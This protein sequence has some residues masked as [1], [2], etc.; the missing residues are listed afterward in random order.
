MKLQIIAPTMSL[1][2]AT[3]ASAFATNS[4]RQLVNTIRPYC[5]IENGFDYQGNDVKNVP[6]TPVDQCCNLCNNVDGCKAWSWTTYNNGTCWLKSARDNIVVNPNVKSSPLY[7]GYHLSCNVQ[8]DVD[9]VGNDIGNAKSP[10]VDGCCDICHNTLGCRAYSWTD[11]NGGTCWLK[12]SKGQAIVKKGV[13]SAIGYSDVT[14]QPTCALNYDVDYVGNDIGSAPSAAPTGCCDICVKKSGCQAYSWT[15][16]NGGTCWLKSA[17]GGTVNKAGVVSAS[18]DGGPQYDC[19]LEAGVDYP[20]NDIANV[21]SVT[22]SAC[23]AFCYENSKCKAYTW[24]D[25]NGG[26]CWLKSDKGTAVP[27]ANVVSGVR[28]YYFP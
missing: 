20:G 18:L 22:S 21:P 2:M 19:K 14:W 13:K 8:N 23:C 25:Y 9:F 17:R 5:Y 15:N 7:S 24:S 16:L 11:L 10:S 4:F 12:S 27:K 1:L 28:T 26:T 6:N 3:T